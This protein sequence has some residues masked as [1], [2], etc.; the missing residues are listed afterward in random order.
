MQVTSPLRAH[1]PHAAGGPS[2]RRHADRARGPLW[3]HSRSK[4]EAT[5]RA[6]SDHLGRAAQEGPRWQ[7]PLGGLVPKRDEWSSLRAFAAL[8]RDR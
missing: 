6:A 7:G 8:A 1:G 3:Q 2:T 4:L 5:P